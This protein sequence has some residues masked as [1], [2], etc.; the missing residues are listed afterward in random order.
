LIAV[1]QQ[2]DAEGF[3]GRAV[4]WDGFGT[5]MRRCAV[6]QRM[7]RVF[8]G[9]AVQLKHLGHRNIQRQFIFCMKCR[10]IY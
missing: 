9:V 8:G 7:A 10:C 3:A 2:L 5:L 1:Q 4:V 6:G